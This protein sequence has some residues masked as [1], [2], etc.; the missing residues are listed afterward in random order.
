[1][2]EDPGGPGRSGGLLFVGV[3]LFTAFLAATGLAGVWRWAVTAV[4]LAFALALTARVV[5]R[6]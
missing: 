3:L 5:R 6:R 2:T 1:V 4:L